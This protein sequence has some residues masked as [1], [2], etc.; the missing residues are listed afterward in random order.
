V[1]VKQTRPSRGL[2]GNVN[3]K[4]LSALEKLTQLS[5]N[6]LD[7]GGMYCPGAHRHRALRVEPRCALVFIQNDII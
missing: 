3:A 6:V 1:S 4:H 7:C 5:A 2:L